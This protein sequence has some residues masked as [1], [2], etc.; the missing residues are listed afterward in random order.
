M[1]GGLLIREARR[2]SGL[3]QA[4]L[5]VRLSTKQSVVARWESGRAEPSFHSVVKA[6]R[7]CGLDLV[8]QLVP[9]D[10][11]EDRM[12]DFHLAMSPQQRADALAELVRIGD[13]ARSARRG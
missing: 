1:R 13:Q 7:A 12:I 9:R 8:P 10:E 5:A 11:S 2:R 3:T 6:I 4:E